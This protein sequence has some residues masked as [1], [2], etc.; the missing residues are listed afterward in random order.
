MIPNPFFDVV[1]M[2]AGLLRIPAW[3][4]LLA[5]WT[6]NIIK[7]TTIALIGA[8]TIVRISPLLQQWMTK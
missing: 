7:A 2:I 1:G 4:F 3:R 6:G 5:C 8:E